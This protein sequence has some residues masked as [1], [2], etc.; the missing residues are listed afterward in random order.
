MKVPRLGRYGI[1][2]R[3][4]MMLGALQ[5]DLIF[6]ANRG[7]TATQSPIEHRRLRRT[8]FAMQGVVIALSIPASLASG[9]ETWR[10]ADFRDALC[11]GMRTEVRLADY[12]RADCISRTHAIEVEWADKFKEG[13][14]QSL[15]Y[16]TTTALV[17]GLILICRRPE[18]S[19][20][21]NS[22]AAQE[23]FAA[24][25]I[26]ATVWECGLDARIL[27][28]CLRRDIDPR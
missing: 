19:C 10:E 14:G 6:R 2:S 11:A 17:P 9:D 26:E 7:R 21:R 5:A 22:L 23:T 20:L 25:G 8:R 1:H 13:V 4:C 3:V 18:D 28:D 24:F 15:T 16:S 27:S 12:G